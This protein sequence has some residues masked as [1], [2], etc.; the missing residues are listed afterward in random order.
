MERIRQK[1]KKHHII[2]ALAVGGIAFAA[3]NFN[4]QP[5]FD[6]T[7]NFVLFAREEIK[8]EQDV[9]I[10]SGDLGSNKNLDI[11]KDVIV[12]GNLFAKEITLDKNTVINGNASFNKLKLHKDVQI[13]GIQTKP[14]QLPIANLPEIIDFQ[15]GTQNLKFEG[16][17]NILAAGNYRDVVFEKNSRLELS[18]GIYNLRKLELKENSTLIFN[19]SATLNIQFKL[20]GKDHVSVLPGL[21]LKPDDLKINYLGIRPKKEKEERE[22]DDDEINSEMDD[23]E[24]KDHK[25]GKI[26][27]PIVFGKQSFFNFKL[28]AS[29][30]SV[31]IGKESTLRGQVLARKIRIGEDS[32]L[33]REE[34]FEKESDFTKIVESD[35]VKFIMN[36]MVIIFKGSIKVNEL[37][38]VASSVNGKATGF[39]PDLE[40]GKIE[41]STRTIEELDELINEIKNSNN[42]LIDEVLPNALIL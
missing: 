41:V 4:N 39:L 14:V 36:E 18:G 29:R 24:K 25:A 30:A 15:I 27:R 35:G 26:S 21:N 32:I 7:D 16:A 6:N 17:T 1:V 34:V 5:L 8:L 33:S 12:N 11:E 22:D 19:A 20:R 10:S 40:I 38:D 9:Q 2:S 23:K 28:L 42:P 13:L 31:H 3:V 37:F